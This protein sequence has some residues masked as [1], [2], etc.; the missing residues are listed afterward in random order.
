MKQPKIA[1]ELFNTGERTADDIMLIDCPSCGNTSYYN[2]GFNCGCEHCGAD[3]AD[4]S[5]DAYL[6][7]D[8]LSRDEIEVP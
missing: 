4:F 8:W 3:I 2:Q 6:L 7:D 1:L 5:D